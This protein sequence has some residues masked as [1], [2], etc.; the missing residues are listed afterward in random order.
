VPLTDPK[1]GNNPT[2]LRKS[3]QMKLL[4]YYL[5]G[6]KGLERVHRN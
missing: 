6:L 3:L 2:E 5:D 4:W 1:A